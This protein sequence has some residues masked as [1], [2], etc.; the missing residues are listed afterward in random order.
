MWRKWKKRSCQQ[1]CKLNA[2]RPLPSPLCK[3]HRVSR[4]REKTCECCFAGGL[5]RRFRIWGQHWMETL[6]WEHCR[7]YLS[8]QVRV[9]RTTKNDQIWNLVVEKSSDCCGNKHEDT[10]LKG[11]TICTRNVSIS[12]IVG[13]GGRK[14]KGRLIRRCVGILRTQLSLGSLLNVFPTFLKKKKHRIF[15]QLWPVWETTVKRYELA[16]EISSKLNVFPAS[17]KRAKKPEIHFRHILRKTN[18]SVF[19]Y[20]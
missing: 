16:R 8:G 7:Q 9:P 12:R 11:C 17:G 14:M 1:I 10:F 3:C 2:S 15:T 19:L 6:I 18:C 5:A 20:V 4:G 13:V